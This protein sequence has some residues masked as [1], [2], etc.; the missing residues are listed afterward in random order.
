[1]T[2]CHNYKDEACT[3]GCGAAEARGMEA[4]RLEAG[5]CGDADRSFADPFLSILVGVFATVFSGSDAPRARF[6]LW[7]ALFAPGVGC[8]LYARLISRERGVAVSSW[9]SFAGASLIGLFAISMLWFMGSLIVESY[10]NYRGFAFVAGLFAGAFFVGLVPLVT[11]S[12]FLGS[13]LRK[14]PVPQSP[15]LNRKRGHRPG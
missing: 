15:T 11:G 4:R 13:A 9:W 14:P 10:L 12:I 1:M 6:L 8:M 3:A 7:L 5:V 2:V